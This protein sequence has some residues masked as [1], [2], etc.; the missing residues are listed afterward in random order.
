MLTRSPRYVNT[1]PIFVNNDLFKTNN[2]LKF[3]VCKFF[4]Q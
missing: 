3:E 2:T 4:S 1:D